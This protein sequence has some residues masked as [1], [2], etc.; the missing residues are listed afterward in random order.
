[1]RIK[2]VHIV[3]LLV[4]V[5]AGLFLYAA[6]RQGGGVGSEEEFLARVRQLQEGDRSD[7]VDGALPPVGTDPGV[8]PAILVAAEFDAGL[9]LSTEVSHVKLP[10]ANTGKAPLKLSDV[11]TS[12]V[13]TYP[14]IP[15]AQ[16]AIAPG[17][18]GYIDIALIPGRI[19]GFHSEKT[20]TV[21]SSDPRRPTVSVK[22]R[23]DVEPE[24]ELV[25]PEIDFGKVPK[26]SSPEV[27]IRFRQ[28]RAEAIELKKVSEALGDGGESGPP[29]I[30][31]GIAP[32]PEAEWREAGKAEYTIT[33]K[34]SPVVSPGKI[35]KRVTVLT[36]VARMPG[37][38]VH[39]KGAVDGPY[40]V[41]P[42]YPGRLVLKA[43]ADG[44]VFQGTAKVVAEG[45]ID[46]VNIDTGHPQLA[47]K[48][49]QGDAPNT[50]LL[51]V[52]LLPGAPPGKLEAVVRFE[53]QC[54]GSSFPERVGVRSFK[55]AHAPQGPEQGSE[56]AGSVD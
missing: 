30:D 46:V 9:I 41:E 1:M 14:T 27:V 23:V 24:F 25:P 12:C 4:L 43:S 52:S 48:A 7:S 17:A 2:A 28:I 18:E 37:M 49:R 29:D 34:L 31:F 51:D 40:A 45:L 21:Y 19:P 15:E 53:V 6:Y 20:I 10:V 16:G 38:V 32:V 56:V 33:A 55:Q 39:A 44:M 42:T 8:V 13:C 35:L 11:Q 26:G 5:M 54:G 3:L 47:V 22:V 36:N 50:A